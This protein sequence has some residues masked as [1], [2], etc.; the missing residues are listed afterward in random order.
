MHA[1]NEELACG[2]RE[3]K[4]VVVAERL[5]ADRRAQAQMRECANLMAKLLVGRRG[6]K[7]QMDGMW[8]GVKVENL[9]IMMEA[10]AA[11]WT[12]GCFRYRNICNLW[13]YL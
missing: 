5:W 10:K 11:T 9:K 13:S 6:P 2:L 8:I 3:Q 7:V 4:E 12:H 1:R